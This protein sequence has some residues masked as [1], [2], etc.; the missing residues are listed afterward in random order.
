MADGKMQGTVI[1][2]GNNQPIEGATIQVE[3]GPS[4]ESGGDGAWGPIELAPGTYNL[5]VTASGYR[6]GIYEN[7]VV[8]DN[9]TTELT[10]GLALAPP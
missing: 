2:V 10:F 3:N 4:A 7:I 5:T 6:D 9:D 8:L 1:F